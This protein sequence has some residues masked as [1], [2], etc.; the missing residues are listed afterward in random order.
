VQ[1][2]LPNLVSYSQSGF[3]VSPGTSGSTV[4]VLGTET[5][6]HPVSALTTI[7]CHKVGSAA[8]CIAVGASPAGTP[9]VVETHDSGLHWAF[10]RLPTSMSAVNAISCPSAERCFL[11]GASGTAHYPEIL[12]TDDGGSS[13]SQISIR[14][15]SRFAQAPLDTIQC[16]TT[17][18]CLAGA[19][20]LVVNAE[21]PGFEAETPLLLV[22]SP[23]SDEF[24]LPPWNTIGALCCQGTK[25]IGA[26]EPGLPAGVGA[27]ACGSP[28]SCWLL[29]N[30]QANTLMFLES[31]GGGI[32]WVP[33]GPVTTPPGYGN[34]ADGG[35]YLRCSDSTHCWGQWQ[36]ENGLGGQQPEAPFATTDGRAWV[37]ETTPA[38]VA[39]FAS[40][41]CVGTADCTAVGTGVADS[42]DGGHTWS[43]DVPQADL[44]SVGAS[45]L[46]DVSCVGADECWA[47][48]SGTYGAFVLG[49]VPLPAAPAAAAALPR[50]VAGSLPVIGH[51]CEPD[52]ALS[53]LSV[54]PLCLPEAPGTSPPTGSPPIAAAPAR[55]EGAVVNMKATPALGGAW[56][57]L[58]V[59][60][61]CRGPGA[62]PSS[63]SITMQD[64]DGS[65][66]LEAGIRYLAPT[67][68]HPEGSDVFFVEFQDDGAGSAPGTYNVA[69][70]APDT[71]P[72][73]KEVPFT[74]VS[75]LQPLTS[76][77]IGVGLVVRPA[78]G[79]TLDYSVAFNGA[80]P[81]SPSPSSFPFASPVFA[82]SCGGSAAGAGGSCDPPATRPPGP[83]DTVDV[84]SSAV[85]GN[86]MPGSCEV[87][88]TFSALH[89]DLHGWEPLP[90]P[91]VALAANGS[92]LGW[93]AHLG[94][95]LMPAASLQSIAGIAQMA[96][97][98]Q[99]WLGSRPTADRP[100]VAAWSVQTASSPSAVTM[101]DLPCDSFAGIPSP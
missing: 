69:G 71:T 83:L 79:A 40:V 6:P 70:S 13:W 32:K 100:P 53:S 95:W 29:G 63:S 11:A 50:C 56:G 10:E 3:R 19:K 12:S 8:D 67:A 46:S 65:T 75:W 23:G 52:F 86:P 68:G 28:T 45:T 81:S 33:A 73:G 5:N 42:T 91:S 82:F 18:F 101:Q 49:T 26:G 37:F 48:G 30:N 64:L 15:V 99:D 17:T 35:A 94:A 43:A 2:F 54:A 38:P 51:A 84:L 77:T 44:S 21:S 97:Y 87:P 22:L 58:S 60:P 16:P 92:T 57:E 61:A 98:A 80:P 20:A 31:T 55:L 78:A 24:V 41:S 25:W 93:D 39:T 85:A 14:G 7:S 66:Y 89:V 9:V 96:L 74:D 47:V 76:P 34:W 36:V 90:Q 62:T 4:P 88:M 72:S 1:V 59:A 27:V